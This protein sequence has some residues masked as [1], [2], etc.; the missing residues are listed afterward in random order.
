MT[1]NYDKFAA[2][3]F[4]CYD[5]NDPTGGHII[6][7]NI[8]GMLKDVMKAV[9]L[10]RFFRDNNIP[11]DMWWLNSWQPPIAYAPK[12]VPTIINYSANNTFMIAG[13]VQIQLPNSYVASATASNVAAI[14]ESSRPPQS[15]S[16]NGDIQAQAWTNTTP[17]GTLN[18]VAANTAGQPQDGNVDLAETDLS[19]ASPGEPLQFTRYYQSSWLGGDAMGPGWV[20]TPYVLQ[21]SRPSWYDDYGWMTDN[22]GYVLPVLAGTSDTGLRS[23]SLRVVNMSTGTTLDFVSSLVLGYAVNANNQPYITLYGLTD[24][25]VPAFTPGQRQD[26]S[27]LIQTPNQMEYQLFTP[28]G[29]VLT[30]DH[31]GK[32]LSIQD[33]NGWEQDY[34][35]DSAGHLLSISDDAQQSLVF[36]YDAQTNYLM[37]V[38]GPNGEEVDYTYTTNGCLATATHVRSGATVSYGYNTNNQLVSKTLFNGLN[39][40]QPQPDLRG[41]ANTNLDLRGNATVKTFTQNSTGTVR[42]NSIWDPQNTDPQFVPAQLQRDNTGRLLASRTVTGARRLSVT[43]RIRYGQM[44]WPCQL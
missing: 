4:P 2:L 44:P 24:A 16:S 10:A 35:Y 12:S 13:G 19:F 37:S 6:Q 14:V 27:V 22:Y 7:T 1:A 3:Q 5:P 28:D 40:L 8:F 26:G 25:D 32:L 43:T 20:Y 30:F 15:G 11:V 23:D 31:N 41:R 34:Q 33:R 18:A 17:V 21:F 9:S 36:T 38:V 29:S 42:T 39:V